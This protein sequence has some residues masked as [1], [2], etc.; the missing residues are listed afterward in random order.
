MS[1][2]PDI[3]KE[4][5]M[6]KIDQLEQWLKELIY[7]GNVDEFVQRPAGHGSPE[8]QSRTYTIYTEENQYT[9]VAVEKKDGDNYL[10]CSATARKSRPGEGWLRGNDLPDGPFTRKTWDRIVYAIVSYEMVKL[11]P[12]QKPDKAPK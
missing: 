8:E 9:I 3:G 12:F 11:S 5:V 4:R 2:N 7:P 6:T 1:V 10:G